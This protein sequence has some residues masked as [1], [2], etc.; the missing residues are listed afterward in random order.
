ME[1]IV[2]ELHSDQ[3]LQVRLKSLNKQ[4][5]LLLVFL[6][7]NELYLC[8]FINMDF[9]FKVSLKADVMV[10]ILCI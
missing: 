9:Q 10:Y 1:Q 7:T 5:K 3:P 2:K 6:V 8:N 4:K